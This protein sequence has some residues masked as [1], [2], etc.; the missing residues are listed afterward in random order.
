MLSRK[1]KPL[2]PRQR[3]A[4]Q[5]PYREAVAAAKAKL[6][7]E[8]SARK[9]IEEA[10]ARIRTKYAVPVVRVDANGGSHV[11]ES[12]GSYSSW[13]LRKLIDKAKTVKAAIKT[14]LTTN[15]SVQLGGGSPRLGNAAKRLRVMTKADQR[16]RARLL[17][18]LAAAQKAVADHV[19]ESWNNGTPVTPEL[20]AGT[21]VGMASLKSAPYVDDYAVRRAE[22]SL[23]EAMKHDGTATCPCGPCDY[24]RKD[25]E[26]QKRYAAE[27]AAREKAEAKRLAKLG[28]VSFTCPG[29]TCGHENRESQ[30][31]EDESWY[32]GAYHVVKVVDCE[33]C[34]ERFPLEDVALIEPD[35]PVPGQMELIAA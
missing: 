10:N 3:L 30:V 5:K 31:D 29:E 22:A 4:Y 35:K 24:A 8:Q 1:R 2:G 28:K 16:K 15:P 17:A 19:V 18:R 6:A 34:D 27:A 7:A 26:R 23:A 11:V 20:L 9:A 13:D 21:L 14:V 25:A 33:E 32:D 12:M